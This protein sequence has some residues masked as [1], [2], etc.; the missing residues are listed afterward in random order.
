MTAALLGLTGCA[1]FSAE[2]AEA[3]I[4]ASLSAAAMHP[5]EDDSFPI[6]TTP[7]APSSS[8]PSASPSPTT[9]QDPCRPA[10]PTIIAACLDAPWGLA[11]LPDGVSALV[12]ERTTG[13]ILRVAPQTEPVEVARVDGIDATG[14]GGL[15][16]IALSPHYAEDGLVYAFVTTATDNRIVRIATGDVPKDVFTGIPRGTGAAGHNGGRIAFGADGYLYVAT[17][18]AGVTGAGDDPN[19]LAGKVLRLDEFGKPAPATDPG[20][21]TSPSPTPDAPSPDTPA[22]PL[23]AVYSSGLSNPTGI[24]ALGTDGVGVVDRFGATDVLTTVTPGSD[25]S[26]V[27]AIWSFPLSDGGAVDCARNDTVLAATSLDAQLVTA[28]TLGTGGGF[29]GSPT[30][31]AKGTY[32]RLLS[33]ETGTQGLLWATTANRD[34]NGEPQPRDDMVVVIPTGGGGS[35]DGL[36]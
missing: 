30:Q 26:A 32:G 17:G 7:V 31:L 22:D 9:P 1:D 24:C 5:Q 2:P 14:D 25:L 16:G 27:P 36:D 20:T 4:Q 29:T 23:S 13:R 18:D 15:L 34:G 10:D 19:T 35:G 33:L 12:G 21:T 8:D 11:V 28:L 6:P 3:T